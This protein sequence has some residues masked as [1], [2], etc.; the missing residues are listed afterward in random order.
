MRLH[1][2]LH[3]T[4]Q[5]DL[6]LFVLRDD[7]TQSL[8]VMLLG[9][10]GQSQLKLLLLFLKS[11]GTHK[12]LAYLLIWL[13]LHILFKLNLA[14]FLLSLH[15]LRRFLLLSLEGLTDCVLSHEGSHLTAEVRLARVETG[16][17][18]LYAALGRKW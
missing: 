15:R 10:V 7:L 12:P 17:H 14:L 11:T 16:I 1:N 13:F 8:R 5:L 4:D 9:R 2:L 18:D 6:R 3:L